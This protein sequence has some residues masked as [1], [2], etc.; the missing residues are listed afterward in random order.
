MKDNTTGKHSYFAK[1]RGLSIM[2]HV[3]ILL[4]YFPQDKQQVFIL[5]DLLIKYLFI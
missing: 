2:F 5:F 1:L 3:G 4:P